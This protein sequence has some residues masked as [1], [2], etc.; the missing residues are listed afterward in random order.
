MN[1]KQSEERN[2]K[3]IKEKNTPETENHKPVPIE[4]IPRVANLILPPSKSHK[5]SLSN[6]KKLL[7]EEN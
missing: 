5:F 6:E 4:L 3:P 2:A 1:I 7:R